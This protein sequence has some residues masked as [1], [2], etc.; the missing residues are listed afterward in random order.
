MELVYHK[1]Q[2]F[3]IIKRNY[4][5]LKT[6]YCKTD[7]IHDIVSLSKLMIGSEIRDEKNL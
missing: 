1:I 5:S 4:N 2:T 3:S 6:I 7:Y